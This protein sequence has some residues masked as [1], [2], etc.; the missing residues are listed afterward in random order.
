MATERCEADEAMRFE[1]EVGPSG[2]P[3]PKLG[4]AAGPN[5]DTNRNIRLKLPN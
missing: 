5:L 2:R 1:T 4:R 3:K